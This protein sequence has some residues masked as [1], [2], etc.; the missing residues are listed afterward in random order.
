MP[1]A[2]A[3]KK[4]LARESEIITGLM[5]TLTLRMVKAKGAAVALH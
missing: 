2:N 4:Q 1:A 5:V 3:L